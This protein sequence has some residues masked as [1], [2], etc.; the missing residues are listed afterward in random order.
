MDF[1]AQRL[2][3]A[4]VTHPVS[5]SPALS[6]GAARTTGDRLLQRIIWLAMILEIIVVVEP[7]PVDAVLMLALAAAVLSGKLNFSALTPGVLVSI[8]LFALLNLVS[9]YD[10]FNPMRAVTYVAVTLYL[11]ASWFLFAGLIGRYGVPL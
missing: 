10:P 8:G 4:T 6:R 11:V 1:S 3:Y 7:A 2:S 9:M 5:A